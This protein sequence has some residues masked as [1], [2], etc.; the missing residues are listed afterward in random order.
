MG[1]LLLPSHASRDQW[2]EFRRHGIGASEIAAVMGISPY[3]SPFSLYWQKT[4]DWQSDVND[5]MRTGTFL[6]ATI[7]DWYAEHRDPHENLVFDTAGLY[8]HEDRP[9]Q[10]ATPDRLIY[11]TCAECD[12]DQPEDPWAPGCLFCGAR[13]YNPDL[14]ALLECKWVAASW[15]GWGED[16]TDRIP[17]HYRAQCLWQMDVMGVDEVFVAALG[18]TGFRSYRIRRDEDDLRVMREYGRR[19][20]QRIADKE[21]PDIDEHSSTLA[22]VKRLHADIDDVDAEIDPALAAGY[23]RS[24]RL[25]RLAETVGA[26]YDIAIRAAMGTARRAVCNGRTVATRTASD[27]LQPTRS[28]R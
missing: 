11:L 27:A 28:T 10:L 8:A 6:E 1:V 3:E 22:I 4:N 2:R 26:R 12:G 19:F 16:G 18:P 13:G 14:A 9:W 5:E 24:R 23:L 17:V 7:A 20:M 21:P 15:D 25:K